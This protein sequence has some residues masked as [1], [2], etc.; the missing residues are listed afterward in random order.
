MLCHICRMGKVKYHLERTQAAW[1]PQSILY[2]STWQGIW[3]RFAL[4]NDMDKW[5][6]LHKEWYV[7]THSCPAFKAGLAT[8][9]C[10]QR[11]DEW[12]H[13][14]QS[15]GFHYM[16][17][18]LYTWPLTEFT[19]LHPT[20]TLPSP[21]LRNTIAP[22]PLKQFNC[23]I[24]LQ[25]DFRTNIWFMSKRS[26]GRYGVKICYE[27]KTYIAYLETMSCYI[28]ILSPCN[29]RIAIT[30]GFIWIQPCLLWL[31]YTGYQ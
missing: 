25:N 5:L 2:V 9:H 27:R 22:V 4:I 20:F 29:W 17:M 26:L 12:F 18:P 3:T 28:Y 31:A 14:T 10:S 24:V 13:P 16:S 19:Y 30:V 21:S 7:I 1:R 8:R 15:S 6:Y 23:A 11:L